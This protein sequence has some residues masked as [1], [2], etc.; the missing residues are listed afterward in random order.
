[1]QH[2]D[3][4]QVQETED[5]ILWQL[6]TFTLNVQQLTLFKDNVEQNI[7]P[8][9]VALLTYL[10]KKHGQYATVNELIEQV[11]NGRFVSDAAVRGTIRKLRVALGDTTEAPQYIQSSPGR[12]YRLLLQPTPIAQIPVA[13]IPAIQ[14]TMPASTI[15]QVIYSPVTTAKARIHNL[16][17]GLMITVIIIAMFFVAIT[18][19]NNGNNAPGETPFQLT[20]LEQI[21]A[22]PSEKYALDISLDQ[23]RVAFSARTDAASGY[24]LF[25]L[26]R[27]LNQV[28]QLTENANNITEIK[29]INDDRDLV[30]VDLSFKDSKLTV[31]RNIASD[32]T[33]HASTIVLSGY[34]SIAALERTGNT[35]EVY[36]A[37]GPNQTPMA[38]LHKI[39]LN[40]G[41]TLPLTSGARSAE[42][43][44]LSSLSPDQTQLAVARKT[45]DETTKLSVLLAGTAAIKL[46]AYIRISPL[47]LQWLANDTL[48]LTSEQGL[49]LFD[50]ATHSLV[51]NN[52]NQHYLRIASRD[53]QRFYGVGEQISQSTRYFKEQ[54]LQSAA[55]VSASRIFEF[56]SSV[57]DMFYINNTEFLLIQNTIAGKV[58]ASYQ[59]GEQPTTL[60]FTDSHTFD[61]VQILARHHDGM[62][63]LANLN[64][65][66]ALITPHNAELTFITSPAAHI[67]GGSFTLQGDD[68][69][70]AEKI[71]DQWHIMRYKP[72]Q[73]TSQRLLSNFY[74]LTPL[75]QHYLGIGTDG[76]VLLLN[77]QFEQVSEIATDNMPTRINPTERTMSLT[78][79]PDDLAA[80]GLPLSIN[81]ANPTLP[82][83]S[84]DAQKAISREETLHFQSIYFFVIK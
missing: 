79:T 63:F 7:E 84:P 47:S 24:Q 38:V 28:V 19:L 2:N 17:A 44:Y 45:G 68:I 66:L 77:A 33:Q 73:A 64:N 58:L 14:P 36:A 61:T 1:M 50:I 35:D 49:Y 70:Y 27:K 53:G 37:L 22:F 15:E 51:K 71:A 62:H 16:I 75:Q 60:K 25:L 72:Q 29:F 26:D 23:R 76:K 5:I 32:I 34:R 83:F 39:N 9:A 82:Q 81:F 48:L 6:G 57:E 18:W 54:Q 56:D 30:Y 80:T 52:Q 74:A 46:E 11:W 20:E 3:T 21:T 10:G 69:L 31:L 42:F 67:S 8:K 59:Q 40:S 4:S 55:P 78:F 41:S 12:G 43:D 65:Q 13:P